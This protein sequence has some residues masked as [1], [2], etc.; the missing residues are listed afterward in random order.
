MRATHHILPIRAGSVD[1]AT[2]E[3]Q[4]T[5]ADA[6]QDRRKR[7]HGRRDP[8][9]GWSEDSEGYDGGEDHDLDL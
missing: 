2:D 8:L 4:W 6:R 1:D 9:T 5:D 3:E 7:G